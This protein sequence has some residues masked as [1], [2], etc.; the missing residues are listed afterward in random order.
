MQ[1]GHRS[2]RLLP[3]DANSMRSTDGRAA[4]VY[5]NDVL[6]TF[7]RIYTRS[8][9]LAAEQSSTSSSAGGAGQEQI[10][11]VAEDPSTII[12]FEVPEGPPPEHIE[13]EGEGTEEMDVEKVRE[14]L[15]KRWDIYQS[16]AEEMKEAL[17]SKEL[18]K[19]NKVL[20]ELPVD[21][22][23][24]LVA[25]LDEAGILSFSSSE[26]SAL[27]GNVRLGREKYDKLTSIATLLL[28]RRFGTRPAKPER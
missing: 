16:F 13:L 27:F 10:Q 23:E 20:G 22:A 21:E 1:N 17:K 4:V 9:Q 7:A 28:L 5:F 6:S 2:S 26:V 14:F 18:D 8:Q 15:Q 11:L 25:K 3:V 24:D 12:G 19:V